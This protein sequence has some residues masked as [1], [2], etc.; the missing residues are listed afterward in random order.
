ME[1]IWKKVIGF[2]ESYEVNNF[3]NVRSF[4]RLIK[5]KKKT[6]YFL[7]F[8]GYPIKQ[9]LSFFKYLCVSLKK[10]QKH[11]IKVVHRLVA[12]AFLENPDNKNQVNHIDGNKEN[13]CVSN[14]EWVTSSENC[15]HS[16]KILGRKGIILTEIE[17]RDIKFNPIYDSMMNK[18]IAAKFNV[19]PNTISGIRNGHKWKHVTQN[20]NDSIY[21]LEIIK[22]PARKCLSEDDKDTILVLRSNGMFHKDIADSFGVSRACIT[23]FLNKK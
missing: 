9:K 19:H 8:K 16:N 6:E 7:F 11:S 4:D 3:G 17:V 22:K 12:E 21:A 10:N 20:P 13:N 2:E 18:D 5:C 23:K 1:E 15:I 14:L